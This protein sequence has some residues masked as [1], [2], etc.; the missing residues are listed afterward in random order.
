MIV[1][2][3]VPEP[4]SLNTQSESHLNKPTQGKFTAAPQTSLALDSFSRARVN[5]ENGRN[6][7]RFSRRG[8]RRIVD[9]G[10]EGSLLWYVIS[11]NF[12][13]L[14]LESEDHTHARSYCG[15]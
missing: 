3:V 1:T 8:L 7:R 10:V 6:H 2:N 15:R 13:V 9:I 14:M 5:S 4:G 12:Q 11:A